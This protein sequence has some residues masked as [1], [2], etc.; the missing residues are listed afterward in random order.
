MGANTPAIQQ[1]I[2]T[3]VQ[4]L[5]INSVPAYA[6][7]QI[8]ALKDITDAL[9][10]LE[11][12]ASDDNSERASMNQIGQEVLVADEQV[13]TLTSIVDMTDA[14]VA[15]TTITSLRD[16]LTQ[17]FHSSA[18]LDGTAGV[19]GVWLNNSTQ[20]KYG[21]ILRNGQWYRMH[22]IRLA[23]RLDYETTMQN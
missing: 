20:G 23:V 18:H 17:C 14:E 3:M 1:A 4:G 5:Q 12:T 11:I 13:F 2:K 9:P 10:I 19:I 16:V 15:E 7:V 21:Y 22:Q 8:G 6:T